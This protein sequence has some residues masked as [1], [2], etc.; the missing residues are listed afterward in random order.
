[1]MKPRS[2]RGV[3]VRRAG[4]VSISNSLKKGLRAR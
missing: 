3:P 4:N 2:E 1:V